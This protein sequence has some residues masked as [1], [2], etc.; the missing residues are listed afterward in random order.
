MRRHIEVGCVILLI[1]GSAV[2]A[3]ADLV[4]SI[5]STSVAQ[6][7][8]GELDVYLGSTASPMTPDIIN[9]YAFTLQIT[10]STVGN[11]A[12]STS[13]GFGYLNSSSYVF[14]GDSA[15][16]IAG[17]SSPP[18]AGGTPFTSMNGYLNDSFL[19]FDNTNDFA[20]VSLSTNSGQVLLATL[21]LDAS[22]TSAGET[23]TVSLVPD[24]GSGSQNTSSSTY[25]NVVD[26]SFNEISAVPFTSTSG[27][28]TITPSAV[29]EP[30]SIIPGLSALAILACC[31]AQRRIKSR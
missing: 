21:A 9:D 25:F 2:S 3:R 17:V 23:F 30:S 29:P 28:M 6:G 13:Q 5:A 24:S 7:G 31:H 16:Y 4:V 19:G 1:A 10:P 8:T 14:F 18:P 11:L 22:I 20:S 26:S 12:F 27:T 15:D